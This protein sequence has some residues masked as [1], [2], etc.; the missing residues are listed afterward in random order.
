MV[1]N[2]G[3]EV[4]YLFPYSPRLFSVLPVN[5]NPDFALLESHKKKIGGK[6]LAMKL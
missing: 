6:T 5:V 2:S 4:F 3:V 1:V